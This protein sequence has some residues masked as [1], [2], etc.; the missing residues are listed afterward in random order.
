MNIWVCDDCL[1]VCNELETIILKYSEIYNKKLNVLAFDSGESLLK[2]IRLG[3]R[4]DLIFLDI[5]LVNISGVN[6]AEMMRRE[7]RDYITQIVFVS[8][9]S[10]YAMQLFKVQPLD[11]ILKPIKEEVVFEMIDLC[12]TIMKQKQMLFRYQFGFGEQS[13][14]FEDI[15]GFFSEGHKI[16]IRTTDGD[17]EFYGKL[18]DIMDDLPNT[19][20]QIHKSYIINTSYIVEYKY[21]YV[22]LYNGDILNISRPK[23]KTVRDRMLAERN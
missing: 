20:I 12:E 18:K 9:I 5:E 1:E 22:I 2:Y 8:A 21:E 14:L 23:R 16:I 17:R 7:M 11:F 4:C 13:V 10:S 19:F 15:V 6:V 3:E